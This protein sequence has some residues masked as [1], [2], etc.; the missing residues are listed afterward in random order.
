VIVARRCRSGFL[1]V[2]Q[3]LGEDTEIAKFAR[4][5]FEHPPSEFLGARRLLNFFSIVVYLSSFH[6]HLSD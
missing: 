5:V 4:L 3:T 6:L 2:I 1:G